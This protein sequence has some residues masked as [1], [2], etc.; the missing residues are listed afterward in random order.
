MQ[1]F[2][3]KNR[4]VM[5]PKCKVWYILLLNGVKVHFPGSRIMAF[6]LCSSFELILT[7]TD[8]IYDVENLIC[9]LFYCAAVLYSA[10]I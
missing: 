1:S 10:L 4:S 3:I 6:I 5:F 2:D 9:N 8:I 7:A